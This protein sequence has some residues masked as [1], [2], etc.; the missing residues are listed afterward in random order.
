MATLLSIPVIIAIGN[1]SVYLCDNNNSKGA[2]F[3]IRLSSPK[4][5]IEIAMSNDALRWGYEGDPTDDT[6]RGTANYLLWMC[7][8]YGQQAQYIISGAGGGTV[9]PITGAT[10]SPIQFIVDASTSYMVDGQSTK[11]VT[12]FIGF[13]LLFTR[14]GI[15][16]ST[17]TS[18]PSFYNWDKAAGLFTIT[19]SANTGELFQIYAI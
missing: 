4:S 9:I 16:Q 13:N 11:T 6:L 8:K 7:G 1:T 17:V 19:P 10:P 5:S 12:T 3:G 14:G 15:T 18:E 2:L